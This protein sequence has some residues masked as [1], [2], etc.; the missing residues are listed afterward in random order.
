MKVTQILM[1]IIA[2]LGS[3]MLYATDWQREQDEKLSN[4]D[5]MISKQSTILEMQIKYNKKEQENRLRIMRPLYIK[6]FNTELDR[7]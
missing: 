5:K 2:F 4:L 6:E 3:A 1:L 7:K